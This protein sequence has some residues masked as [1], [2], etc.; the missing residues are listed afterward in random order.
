MVVIAKRKCVQLK[1]SWVQR[2]RAASGRV[3]SMQIGMSSA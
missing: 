2:V 1:T 3:L